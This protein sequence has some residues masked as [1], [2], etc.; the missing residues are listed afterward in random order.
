MK[1]QR[2]II[3]KFRSQSS[4]SLDI[5][6]ITRMLYQSMR[7]AFGNMDSFNT[8]IFMPSGF[9]GD[10]QCYSSMT[11]DIA[12]NRDEMSDKEVTLLL[13]ELS[14]VASFFSEHPG[15]IYEYSGMNSLE[16]ALAHDELPFFIEGYHILVYAAEAY[17]ETLVCG[18]FLRGDRRFSSNERQSIA[19][20]LDAYCQQVGKTAR[21]HNRMA[22]HLDDY[23]DWDEEEDEWDEDFLEQDY[24][25]DR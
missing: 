21:V 10:W 13:D 17:D 24:D 20:L 6:E 7:G 2:A 9:H 18:I 16:K 22:Q 8:A 3:E 11:S 12:P 14:G 25:D 19:N 15:T 5:P 23:D 1:T 4:E